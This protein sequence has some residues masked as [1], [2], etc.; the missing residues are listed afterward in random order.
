MTEKL[1]EQ[2]LKNVDR[3]ENDEPRGYIYR[4]SRNL[5]ESNWNNN[6]ELTEAICV[7]LHVWNGAFYR[8]G[9]FDISRLEKWITKNKNILNRLKNKKITID[10]IME[11]KYALL[12]KNIFDELIKV[13]KIKN[14]KKKTPVGVAKTLHLLMPEFFPLWDNAIAKGMGVMWNYKKRNYSQK[15]LECCVKTFNFK[16][17]I[18]ENRDIKKLANGDKGI[19]KIIDEFNYMKFTKDKKKDK[20]HKI[21]LKLT[22]EEINYIRSIQ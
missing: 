8:Y 14:S 5:I 17:K 15:Y 22:T 9:F 1:I 19:L 18:K 21:Y 2:I 6:R 20:K 10:N 11:R 7:L 13:I 3:F 4:I 12:V 16:N